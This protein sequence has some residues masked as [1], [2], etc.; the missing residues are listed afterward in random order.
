MSRLEGKKIAILVDDTYED[1]EFWYPK[2]RLI[3]EG[4]EVL[5]VGEVAGAEYKGKHG[6]PAKADAAFADVDGASLDAVV[7]PGGYAPDRIRRNSDA[8]QLVWNAYDAGKPVAIICHAGW[9]AISAGILNNVRATSFEAIRDDMRN[10]GV[11]W[12]DEPVMVDKNVISSRSPDDLPFFCR[13][14]IEKL[15]G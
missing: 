2:I 13:A 6:Y 14:I 11:H 3:E 7:I 12:V 1:L 8:L 10:A 9:V 5:A 4:A 15:S